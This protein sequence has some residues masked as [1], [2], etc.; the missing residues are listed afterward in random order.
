VHAWNDGG[1]VTLLLAAQPF[2]RT[3]PMDMKASLKSATD[4][5]VGALTPDKAPDET[6]VLDTLKKE[7]DEL[8]E[9]LAN[10]VDSDSA[11]ERKSLLK[12][13]KLA[14]VPHSKAEEMIVYDAVIAAKSE[15][16]K[17]QI[18]GAEGYVEHALASAT[19][20]QLDK[21]TPASSPDFTAHAKVLKE[22]I[23]H[24]VQEEERNIWA[25]VKENFDPDARIEM[26]LR[27]L[28]AKKTVRI[29]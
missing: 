13:V 10:L 8:Q 5:L 9:L 6:D 29:P 7:H 20:L 27:Y 18:D 16:Q 3:N 11:T 14:L 25:D 28:A 26:N 23:D 15:E 2:A 21:I 24:H 12:R 1:M 22:L 17:N 19:L 4:K